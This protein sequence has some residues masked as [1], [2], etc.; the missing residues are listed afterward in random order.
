MIKL[1]LT[2]LDDTLIAVGH[3]CASRHALEGA[4]AMFDLGL[5]FGPA[6]GRVPWDLDWMF[7]H[8]AE[9]Y[10][11]GAMIN[12]Q[13]VYIDG[14]LVCEKALETSE[15][16]RMGELLKSIPGTALMIDDHGDRF[17]VGIT[18]EEIQRFRGDFDRIGRVR[19]LVPSKKILKANVH[20][21]GNPK[22]REEVRNLLTY[23]FPCFDFVFPNPKAPLVDIL[24]KGWGKDRGIDVLRREL[25][26]AREEVVS[27]GDAENDLAVLESVPNS[28]TVSNADPKVAAAARWHIG[29]SA[30]DA[31]ADALWD[32]AAAGAI[33]GMP[34]FMC[35][36][37]YNPHS[38]YKP[39]AD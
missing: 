25:G 27:F 22:R 20:V 10:A 36:K 3:P 21:V 7:D 34:A 11:T 19:R 17:A 23:E 37:N 13:L 5:H 33:G 4:H 16:Q 32:I 30:D 24:P 28:V 31:V 29:A 8:D 15:L 18:A 26:L 14:E 39:L 12:G 38:V 2:D 9:A 1:A 35:G 6:T